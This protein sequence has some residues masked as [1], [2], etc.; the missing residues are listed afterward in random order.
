VK[1]L[2][3][4]IVLSAVDNFSFPHIVWNLKV[5]GVLSLVAATID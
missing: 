3:G 1:E 4:P 5:A 2:A